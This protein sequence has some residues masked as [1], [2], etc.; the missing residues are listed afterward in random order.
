MAEKP[1][2]ATQTAIDNLFADI[3]D[4]SPEETVQQDEPETLDESQEA[5]DENP[6]VEDAPEVE[7]D[8]IYLN[9]FASD[10]DVDIADVYQLS[11]KMPNEM[12]D[13]TLTELKDFMTENHDIQEERQKIQERAKELEERENVLRDVP[14]VSQEVIQARARVL[15]IQDQYNA[16]NWEK[17]R[18]ENVAEWTARQQEFRNA[19]DAA[20]AQENAALQTSEQQRVQAMQFAQERLFERLPELKDAD[21]RQEAAGRVEKMVSRYGF[22]AKDIASIADPN[23]MHMLIDL[24][25]L[26]V[27]KEQAK[28]KLENKK[29]APTAKK[30]KAKPIIS[31]RKASLKKLHE[32]ATGGTKKQK[33][34]FLDALLT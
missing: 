11:V 13:V 5:T 27:A 4:E 3:P 20:K 33:D 14:K 15:S 9:D 7:P 29:S 18:V 16:T 23:I 30:P 10:T 17:L 2:L 12:G 24:S 26:D 32:R 21:K 25:T 1:S 19:F 31:T 6:Q 8:K 28:T 34:A 22:S